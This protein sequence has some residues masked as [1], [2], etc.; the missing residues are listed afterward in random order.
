MFI[1]SAAHL[2]VISTFVIP[3]KLL[4]SGFPTASVSPNLI[5]NFLS[6]YSVQL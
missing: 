3:L 2:N 6:S 4:L 1:S 5:W